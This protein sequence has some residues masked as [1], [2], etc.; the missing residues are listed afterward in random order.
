MSTPTFQFDH[1]LH[2]VPDLDEAT[3]RF[4]E[5]GFVISPG[6]RH[7]GGT[8]NAVWLSRASGAYV[9]LI[10][11]DDWRARRDGD[12]NPLV[13]RVLPLLTAGGGGSHFALAVADLA[14]F[15]ATLRRH[16][17]PIGDPQPGSI[18]LE[19]GTTA[20]WA[21]AQLTEGPAWR[22]F[23]IQYDQPL[24]ERIAWME[25]H[26]AVYQDFTIDQLVLAVDDPAG[27]AAWLAGVLALP[28][29]SQGGDV[30]LRLPGCALYLRH[31]AGTRVTG[32]GVSGPAARAGD[33]Y[34]VRYERLG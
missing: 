12:Q 32:I 17:A 19:D 20:T 23:F 6:G 34:G 15:T 9:E 30:V 18:R 21:T 31:G 10:T 4:A 22:P 27:D 28:V 14:A 33:L 8:R 1:L 7:P 3:G 29:E 24:Q 16:G 26:G 13:R 5:H 2:W 11:F 25:A